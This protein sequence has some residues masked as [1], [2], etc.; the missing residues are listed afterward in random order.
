MTGQD[1]SFVEKARSSWKAPCP[2]WVLELASLADSRRLKGAGQAIGY[3]AP[4]VSAVIA[5]SYAG[6]L[7]RVEEKV[8]WT[9]M[10]SMVECPVIGSMS[11]D[12][13]IAWQAKPLLATSSLRLRMYRACHGGCTHF[14]ERG[15]DHV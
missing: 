4:V 7:A 15:A 1:I 14:R 10:T 6:D 13:C 12:A 11:R 5:G 2:D 8:R 3:S 9:L